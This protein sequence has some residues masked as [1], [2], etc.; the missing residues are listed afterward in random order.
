MLR[1]LQHLS[2]YVCAF[3]GL[4][5]GSVGCGKK[6]QTEPI[7]R[8]SGSQ[9][10][11]VTFRLAKT[12]PFPESEEFVLP[13]DSPL[14]DRE[15]NR[16]VT[17]IYIAKTAALTNLDVDATSIDREPVDRDIIVPEYWSILV[18]LTINGQEKFS[19]M[20]RDNVGNYCAM[21]VDGKYLKSLAIT[22]PITNGRMAVRGT[23]DKDE[24]TNLARVLVG[25]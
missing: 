5:C 2:V 24:A 21:F 4:S 20:T 22:A 14:Y 11:R 25:Q 15:G 12:E 7:F 10:I 17:R 9:T 23:Y 8:A 6:V 1:I 19:R 16:K 3:I 13:E 18:G